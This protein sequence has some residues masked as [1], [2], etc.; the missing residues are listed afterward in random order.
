MNIAE[1]RNAIPPSTATHGV[2]I[3]PLRRDDHRVRSSVRPLR[4]ESLTIPTMYGLE[5]SPCGENELYPR[6]SKSVTNQQMH[7]E[8]LNGRRCGSSRWN[9]DVLGR[10]HGVQSE[11]RGSRAAH[12][13]I[14]ISDINA[15]LVERH[16]SARKMQIQVEIRLSFEKIREATRNGMESSTATPQTMGSARALRFR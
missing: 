6:T 13:T 2:S 1:Q 7:D 10:E 14:S 8:D 16:V 4:N 12:S 3:R 5:A 15:Q 11:R 9:D